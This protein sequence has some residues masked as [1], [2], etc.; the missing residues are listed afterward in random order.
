MSRPRNS[1]SLLDS[2]PFWY[3]DAIIYELHV[4]AFADSNADGIGDFPGLVARLDYLRDLGVTAIWLL[5]FYPSPLRDD[6]Y[7]I[8]NYTDVHPSYGTLRDFKRFLDAAHDRGLRV[9]T[10]LAINHT[11]SEHPWFQRARRAPRGHKFRDFY[12]WSDTPDR[13]AQ[14]RVIFQDFETTNWSWDPVAGAYYWH[15]FYSHQPDLNF[16]N[17]HVQKAVLAV[18]DFWLAL[19][20]DGMRLDAVPYLFERD[21]TNCENLPETHAFLKKLRAHVDRNYQGRMFLAEANQ[22]PEDAAAYFGEGDEC[23]MNF[24]FPLMPRMFIALQLQNSFPIVDIL[25]QT[26]K[27]HESCQ[28]A[29]FLRN[30]DEL[31]LEMVTD[32]DRDSM[33][34]TYADDPVMRV[35]VGIRRRLAPLLRVRKKIE[36]LNGLLM[37]LPGTPVLYYGD[38]IGQGDNVY[39]GDRNG[40]RTPMQWSS[41]RNA[42]FSRA[43]PQKLYLPVIIDPEFHYEAVNIEAQ[44]GN[45]ESLLWWMK[46]LIAMRRQHRVF[47]SGSLEFVETDNP[48]VLA[49]VRELGDERVLVVANLSRDPQHTH[50]DLAKFDGMVPIELSGGAKFP[51][52]SC[53]QYGISVGG[54]EFFWLGLQAQAQPERGESKPRDLPVFAGS[55]LAELLL[56]PSNRELISALQAHVKSRR[57]FRGKART[58]RG[59]QVMDTVE[60]REPPLELLLLIFRIEYDADQA[61]VYVMPL[62]W[63]PAADAQAENARREALFGLRVSGGRTATEGI[64]Y[65]PTGSEELS[66]RLLALYTRNQTAAERGRLSSVAEKYLK[67]RLRPERPPLQAHGPSGDQSNTTIFFGHELMLKMFR[68]LEDGEN[69]DVEICHF[70]WDHGYRNA[71]EPLGTVQYEGARMRATLAAVQRYVPSK[72]T[73]WDVTLESLQRSLELALSLNYRSVAPALPSPDLLASASESMPESVAEMIGTHAPFVRLLA[74]R[75]AEL[76]LVLASDHED[77]AFKPEPFAGHYQRSIVQA[78]RDRLTRVYKLLSKQLPNLPDDLKPLAHKALSVRSALVLQL[79]AA[80]KVRVRTSR[81]R[82]HGDYHLGQVLYAGNDFVIIDFEGEPAQ[83][84][85]V[86]RLKRSALYDVCGMLRS[87]HYAATVAMQSERLRLED[88]T[89]LEP[90]SEAWYRWCSA[91]FLGSYLG[92]ARAEPARA[93]FLPNSD[94]ELRALLGLHL[95][96]KCSYELGYEL[97]NRPAWVGVPLTG[98]LS[99]VQRHAHEPLRKSSA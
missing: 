99:L 85:A 29:L 2:D 81:I 37:S 82:C 96:D 36:L 64:V 8:S 9:I 5:P 76:H 78:A 30:H 33:Y 28:W 13:Y 90:W 63:A 67:V 53:A 42:G 35:N 38:E 87:L 1:Q 91:I 66:M 94:D 52:L 22:W 80:P 74:E 15:R 70:L 34:R 62:A 31:T 3:K 59:L 27:I 88:R 75:T 83:S 65:D 48:R 57:W 41:D 26:P 23:H 95:L 17:P 21:G 58:I 86:R 10:E 16:D 47:G 79:E 4:R 6:G 71:P 49:F 19:G 97:N 45:P 18:L 14:A 51:V 25:T 60:L 69:P 46:R 24:H 12:V 7:D 92:R 61:E 56:G 98:L 72:G 32:E 39:L 44:Q 77:P 68:Q 93:V 54:H 55:G 20:V 89:A 40:V 73:A 84:L 11:S 43:N 50:L